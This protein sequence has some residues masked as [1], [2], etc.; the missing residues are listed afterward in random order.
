[1]DER[2]KKRDRLTTEELVNCARNGDA[3]ALSKLVERV[4]PIINGLV[5]KCTNN[6]TLREDLLQDVILR[7]INKLKTFEGKCKFE[8]WTHRITNNHIKSWFTNFSNR[9]EIP[10]S[11]L[12]N[13]YDKEQ[14]RSEHSIPSLR[15]LADEEAKLQRQS[16]VED[17]TPELHA[18]ADSAIRA[19]IQYAQSKAKHSVYSELNECEIEALGAFARIKLYFPE[20][21]RSDYLTLGFTE[22]QYRRYRDSW[23]NFM[24]M[25]RHELDD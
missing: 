22:D 13:E 17:L 21:V 7:I 10:S 9:R 12:I 1:M 20:N 16:L 3:E 24:K 23:T 18:I 15:K 8:T 19:F 14:D 4:K 6:V 11:N 5:Y 2:G 25:E